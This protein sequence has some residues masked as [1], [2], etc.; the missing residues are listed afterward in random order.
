MR[1][2]FY[3]VSPI[4]KGHIWIFYTIQFDNFAL[5]FTVTDAGIHQQAIKDKI[6]D[7]TVILN[8]GQL[9]YGYSSSGTYN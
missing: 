3:D 9:A 4:I 6:A 5:Q 7:I 1:I 8:I 2:V